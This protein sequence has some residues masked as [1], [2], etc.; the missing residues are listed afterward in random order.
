MFLFLVVIMGIFSFSYS[1]ADEIQQS[2]INKIVLSEGERIIQLKKEDVNGDGVK[3]S[4]YMIGKN[5][6]ADSIYSSIQVKVLDG[7]TNDIFDIDFGDFAGYGGKMEVVDFT[8][9][10][11]PEIM[12]SADTGGSGGIVDTRIASFKDNKTN[13]IYG[14]EEN[15][16]FNFTG[17]FIDGFKVEL[18]SDFLKNPLTL[19]VSRNSSSYIEGD[20][21]SKDGKFIGKNTE[22]WSDSFGKI[23]AIDYDGDGTY[24]IEGV[25]R[26]SGAWHADGISTVTS[27]WNYKDGKWSPISAEYTVPLNLE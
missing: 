10:K 22:P 20:I 7:K 15:K 14:E 8:G 21:Y 27:E 23:D 26:I 9:D 18:R 5:L 16:G 19:D 13:I 12:I 4:V 1:Y 6:F 2:G 24:N 3:D 17:K 11:I 25:Q